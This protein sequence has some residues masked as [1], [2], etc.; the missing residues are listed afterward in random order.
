MCDPAARLD[1]RLVKRL[2]ERDA[3]Q[4]RRVLRP[5]PSTGRRV[6]IGGRSLLN[7]AGNDYLGLAQHPKLIEAAT[8]ATRRYGTG[9]G[10]SR[11]VAGHLDLHQQVE[12][13][14]AAFK[15]AEAALL[16]VTGYTANLAVIS[17]LVT[18]RHDL[19]L[20][21]RL[22]HASL[23][24]AARFS[25]ATVRTYPHLQPDKARRLLTRHAEQYPQNQRFLV[26]DSV[27]SMD[28]DTAHLPTLCN[29]CE[30]TDTVLIVDEAH[31]SGILG[32]EGSG[33]I[34]AQ[35]VVGRVPVVVS[36]ASKALGG[37]GGI[38]TGSRT[39]IDALI[40]YARPM[41]Y[42]TAVAPGQAAAL[43]AALAVVSD[44][45][46]RRRQ[47]Q[48]HVQ[49]LRGELQS[50]GWGGLG[51]GIPTPIVPLHVG[52]ADRALALQ[53]RLETAGILASAIRPP[54]VPPGTARVRLS[55]R[56]DLHEA[57]LDQ[58]IKA[59]GPPMNP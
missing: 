8:D 33:L 54:T 52:S 13:D 15:H 17:T 47:L 5:L 27:F 35:G 39:L 53:G 14:F 4:L 21:D 50:L 55:L 45:P 7:L 51:R 38:V 36:T 29:L 30:L 42:S 10:A 26:T 44:E 18:S 48:R 22:N 11:L 59:I 24:D 23:I 56:S 25:G 1:G 34:E 3:S 19:I 57:D 28:G 49:T 41:V 2:A 46:D 12:A 40:N 20:Q 58:V 9:S 43:G 31:G 6:E 32:D 37:L 16:F